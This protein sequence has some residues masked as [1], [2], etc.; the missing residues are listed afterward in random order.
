MKMK[1]L[2]NKQFF[3]VEELYQKLKC[4]DG[5]DLKVNCK[6]KSQNLNS[7]WIETLEM[8]LDSLKTYGEKIT[9]EML[10]QY[11]FYLEERHKRDMDIYSKDITLGW[12]KG[13]MDAVGWF[14]NSNV[15]NI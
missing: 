13:S 2:K 7:G 4:S 5:F 1:S 10:I 9:V 8:I 6:N 12:M 11:K 3:E 15:V 14:L